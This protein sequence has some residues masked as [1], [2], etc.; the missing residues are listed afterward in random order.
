MAPPV[1]RDILD[2]DLMLMDESCLKFVEAISWLKGNKSNS[3]FSTDQFETTAE[4]ISA[5]EKLYAAGATRVDVRLAD[6]DDQ[7]TS[8]L[9]VRAAEGNT[10]RL[11]STIWS[12]EPDEI[13]YY[14]GESSWVLWWD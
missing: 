5:V 9:V 13:H 7:H 2:Y 6:D 12:L 8:T 3:A 4:I 10:T 14:R 11:F 1:N